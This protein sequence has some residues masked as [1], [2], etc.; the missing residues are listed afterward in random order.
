MPPSP[1]FLVDLTL[2]AEACMFVAEEAKVNEH[3]LQVTTSS[4]AVV[5]VMQRK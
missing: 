5:T 2:S 1:Q 4:T 3:N